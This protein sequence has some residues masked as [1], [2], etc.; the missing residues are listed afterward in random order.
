MARGPSNTVFSKGSDTLVHF[1]DP[2]GVLP[3]P[4]LPPPMTTLLRFAPVA[5]HTINPPQEAMPLVM[6]HIPL[7]KVWSI[8]KDMVKYFI[9]R[10]LLADP[11]ILI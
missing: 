10:G 9:P 5:R 11:C 6:Y 2:E 8:H 3:L 1:A 7:D 4:Q